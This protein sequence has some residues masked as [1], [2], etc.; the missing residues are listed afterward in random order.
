VDLTE[1][2]L[3]LDRPTD[4]QLSPDG[5]RVAWLAAPYGDGGEHPDGAVW[6][7]LLDG[8]APA[9]RLNWAQLTALPLSVGRATLPG[10]LHH[11]FMCRWLV[12][13]P[14]LLGIDVVHM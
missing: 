2:V 14:W 12:T 13:V 4:P 3:E 5:A 10:P 1:D 8:S 7:A 6:M 9:R 11:A